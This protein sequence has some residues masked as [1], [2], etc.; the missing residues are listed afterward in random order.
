LHHGSVVFTDYLIFLGGCAGLSALLVLLAGATLRRSAAREP[1]RR[2]RR[3]GGAL[4]W[5]LPRVGPSLDFNP[6]LWRELHRRRP[7]RWVRVVWF[8]Y[9]V[10]SVAASVTT[11]LIRGSTMGG[12]L[13]PFVN[14]FQYSIGLLLV[15]VTSVTSLFE[16]RVRGSLDVLM[17]TPLPTASIV[18]GKWW[19]AF[20]SALLVT[21]IPLG[22]AALV[23][24]LPSSRRFAG[25][26]PRDP[27]ET[28]GLLV[29]LTGL[30]LAYGAAVTSFGLALA[31]WVKRFGV[32]VG[33]SVSA[34]VLLAGG[35][36]MVLLAVGPRVDDRA[37]AFLSPWYGAG[38]LTY[39]IGD[40]WGGHEPV[41]WKIMW[42]V[43]YALAAVALLVA[44]RATFNRCM[45]RMA[46]GAGRP[47]RYYVRRRIRRPVR[48]R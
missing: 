38:E 23:A 48:D 5:T 4:G 9:V 3:R 32:A 27:V 14:A 15:S 10:L 13:A 33:L 2:R 21:V 44:T 46:E 34:F 8:V 22:L 24:V 28:W 40:R 36:V 20:R 39:E 25:A 11:L 43:L 29:L 17:T 42:G 7:S 35:S 6:V 16:E 37:F 1:V 12:E 47:P 18:Y 26:P 45:G 31:T 41:G 19:G 30:M